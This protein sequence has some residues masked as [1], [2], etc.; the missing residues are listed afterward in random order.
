[1]NAVFRVPPSFLAAALVSSSGPGATSRRRRSDRCV[2]SG[3]WAGSTSRELADDAPDGPIAAV[4]R[5][6]GSASGRRAAR[7][8]WRPMP[9]GMR[10]PPV[11]R[12]RTVST[13]VGGGGGSASSPARATGGGSAVLRV[14]ARSRNCI[15]IRRLPSPSAMVWCI[16]WMSAARPPLKPSTTKNSHSGRVRSKGRPRSAWPDRTAGAAIPAREGRRGG[17]GSRCRTRGRPPRSAAVRLTG[18]GWTRWRRRGTVQAGPL[19][20]GA[21]AVEVGR[22]VEDRDVGEGRGEVRILL[23]APHQALGVAHPAVGPAQHLQPRRDRWHSRP[24]VVSG[25]SRCA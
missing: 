16:F 9:M 6:S 12:S 1:M 19:Q 10:R 3:E 7:C 13:A 18:A 15:D 2:H 22:P 21:E 23:E 17:R 5:R 25:G 20:P 8:T 24:A 4:R 11:T 14:A